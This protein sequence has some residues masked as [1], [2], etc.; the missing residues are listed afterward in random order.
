MSTSRYALT[1]DQI[2]MLTY[3]QTETLRTEICD[4]MDRLGKLEYA[5]YRHRRKLDLE[6]YPELAVQEPVRPSLRPAS[7]AV[8]TSTSSIQIQKIIRK[9]LDSGVDVKRIFQEVTQ[10]PFTK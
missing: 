9:A 4:E 2:S 8:D 10:K 1:E 5:L 3:D 7:S 6:R